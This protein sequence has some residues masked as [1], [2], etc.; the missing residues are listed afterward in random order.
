MANNTITINFVTCEAPPAGGYTI[1]YR[2]VG[3]G[4]YR[5]TPNVF[6]SPAVFVDTNDAPGT[7]YEGILQSD[8]GGGKLGPEIPWTT[9]PG[10]GGSGSGS[11]SEPP[12]PCLGYANLTEENVPVSYID[13]VGNQ[14]ETEVTPTSSICAREIL[15]VGGSLEL[16]GGCE[17]AG[18]MFVEVASGFTVT[19]ISGIEHNVAMPISNDNDS[20]EWVGFEGGS[21]DV[22]ILTSITGTVDVRYDGVLKASELFLVG[23]LKTL[24]GLPPIAPGQTFSVHVYQPL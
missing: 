23:G 4:S 20:G 10:G 7:Q 15:S 18:P 11:D 3:G 1:R 22:N 2:P 24:S 19:A 12:I 5:T 14:I 8:C 16:V 13:C 21:V 17:P 6:S 9:S